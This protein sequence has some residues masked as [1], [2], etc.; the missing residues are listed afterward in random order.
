MTVNSNQFQK[1]MSLW[2]LNEKYGTEEKCREAVFRM[3]WPEGYVCPACGHNKGCQIKSRKLYQCHRCHHQT[4]LTAGTIFDST[5]LPLAKWFLAIYLL[6]QAKNGI[7]SLELMRHL[8]VTYRTAWR[9]RH[10]LMEV[11]YER[12]ENKKLK[13]NIEL[14]DA[15]LGGERSGDKRGRGAPGKIPFLA[16][17]EKNEKGHPLYIKL[18][19][20]ETFSKQQVENWSIE[21]IQPGSSVVTDGLS[22]FLGI[23]SAGCIHKTKKV[24]S[25]KQAVMEPAFKWVNTVLGNVKNSLRGTYHVVFEKYAHRYLAEFQYRF[26][27]RF[28]L[29]SLVPRLAYVALRIS[30]RPEWLLKL[31]EI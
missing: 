24:G 6:T 9:L 14:D 13:G 17:V 2:Q 27:R 31:A 8:G 5:K 26:N 16:A 4:S 10:K 20:V 12:N 11:M 18:S 3:K 15:Y 22:C 1:G 30:P 7:S 29:F 19:R 21:N 25:H 23:E 28:D